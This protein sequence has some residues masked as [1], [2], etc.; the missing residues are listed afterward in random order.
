MHIQNGRVRISK[1]LVFHVSKENIGK[2]CQ[3]QHFLE[4]WTLTKDRINQRKSLKNSQLV[5]SPWERRK[6]EHKSDVSAF[7]VGDWLR[8][9]LLS[10]LLEH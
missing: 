1:N 7:E 2:S 6:L 4:P 5:A 10:Y 3:N 9:L 8:D